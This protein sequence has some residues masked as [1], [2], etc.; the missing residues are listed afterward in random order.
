MRD[1]YDAIVIGAGVIGTATALALVDRGRHTLVLERSTLAHKGGSSHGLN[2]IVRLTDFHPEYVRLNRLAMRAWEE[3]E[4][5]AGEEL[6]V[7]TGNLEVGP[8]VQTYADALTAAGERFDWITAGDARERWPGLRFDD[9]EAIFVQEEGGVCFADRTVRAQAR[10]A[11]ER[12]AE[13][14]EDTEAERVALTSNGVEVEAD[15]RTISAPV[16]V[17]AAGAWAGPLLETLRIRLPLTPTLEQVSYYRLEE[18]SPLPTVID[19]SVDERIDHYAVPDPAV[20]GGVK[21]ALDH[22]GP[23][24]DPDTRTY[25]VDPARIERVEAWARRRFEALIP[26][27][28]PETCLYT[29]TRDNDYV[30]DRIGPVVIGSAC[31]GHGF[32]AS[33]AVGRI[34]ADL[35]VGS[36]PPLSLTR[37][38]PDAP[39]SPRDGAGA[40]AVPAGRALAW[41]KVGPSRPKDAPPMQDS[42][43]DGFAFTAQQIC[44]SAGPVLERLWRERGTPPTAIDVPRDGVAIQAMAADLLPAIVVI[45]REQR[46]RDRLRD[47]EERMR[48]TGAPPSRSRGSSSRCAARSPGATRRSRASCA[49]TT[50]DA[51][52]GAS[53]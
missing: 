9:G 28:E 43:M 33:P 31:S 42:P 40:R 53:R 14:R 27:A 23:V 38:R 1:D 34:L 44:E 13:L 26:T 11:I 22:A 4:D 45:E 7:R 35:A 8:G 16:V 48:G 25:E 6:L 49:T 21:L 15:G 47:R 36:P 2:R 20:I 17:I 5:A 41:Y 46:Y 30:L 51:I 12:G 52:S 10:V 37:F 32:K 39:R 3:L 19:Y 50:P 29:N 24:V 18:P